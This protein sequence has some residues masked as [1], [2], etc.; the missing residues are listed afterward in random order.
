MKEGGLFVLFVELRSP[1]P[2]HFLL[3]SLV[4][5]E[6]PQRVVG[7][8]VTSRFHNVSTYIGEVIEYGTKFS[9]KIYLN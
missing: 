9:V 2:Q 5:L 6:S 1:K 8:H 3:H 7:R 4:P